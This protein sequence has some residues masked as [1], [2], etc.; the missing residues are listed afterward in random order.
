[1]KNNASIT[2]VF[3][4]IEHCIL[5]ENKSDA[6]AS[7]SNGEWIK[8]SAVATSE[9]INQVSAAL[10]RKNIQINDKIAIISNNRPEWNIVDLA[11]QQIGAIT[12]PMYPTI[13]IE[14]YAYILNESETKI[15]FVSDTLILNKVKQA[16]LLFENNIEIYSFDIINEQVNWK[17]LHQTPSSQE[18]EQIKNIKSI[19]TPEYLLTIIYTS[20]T[21]GKPKG[22]ML[23]HHNIVSNID[24]IVSGGCFTLDNTDKALSFLPLCHIYERTAVYVYIYYGASIYYAESIDTI[25]DN[26]KEIK[27]SVFA[28]VPRLLEKV[29]DKIIAKGYELKGIKKSIFFWAVNLGLKFDPQTNGIIYNLK[30]AIA[31]KLIFSKWKE[32]LGGNIKFIPS[33]SAALQPRLSRIFWAAQ[34]P[35]LEGYGLTETSPVISETLLTDFRIGCVGPIL[36]NLEVKIAEDGEILVKGPSVMKGYFKKPEATA[37]AIDENGWFHTG[38]IGEFLEGNVL[39]ITDRKKEIF[40]T[41]GGKYISPQLLENKLKESTFI[42]QAIVVG[43]GQKFPSALIVPDFITL[44]NYCSRNEIPFIDNTSIINNPLIIA[45]LNDE[46]KLLMSNIAQYEQVKKI[47]L[48]PKLFSI[49]SGE[50]TPTLKLKR[51]VIHTNNLS[52]IQ[53]IYT[54][55]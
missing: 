49:E 7:K 37:E 23:T 43:D 14:D 26:L 35:I 2:R 27:P 5:K 13:S 48:L 41:S 8:L 38:D 21:T 11:A 45:K 24:G 46:V 20:G 6:L 1:M 18:L 53:S 10:L 28:T 30:L 55:D 16:V 3:D 44:K 17:E 25:G 36:P 34:I 50:L 40:K 51:K 32:A 52:L 54:N 19:I 42:E 22:V 12:V 33:G 39:K 15:V 9:K 29:Y 31:R 47:K 4:M